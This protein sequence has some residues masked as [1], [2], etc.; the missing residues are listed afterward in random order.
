MLEA[1]SGWDAR[2]TF[3]GTITLQPGLVGEEHFVTHGHFY[4]HPDRAEFYATIKGT[5]KLKLMP[6]DRRPTGVLPCCFS[7]PSDSLPT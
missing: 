6:E 4:A 2:R 3:G 5:G 7:A 1:G